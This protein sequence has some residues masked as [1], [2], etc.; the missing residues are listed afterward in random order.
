MWVQINFSFKLISHEIT[1]PSSK[2]YSNVLIFSY[3]LKEETSAE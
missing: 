3:W 2:S 1:Q